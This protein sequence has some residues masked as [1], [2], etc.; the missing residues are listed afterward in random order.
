VLSCSLLALL[1]LPPR[2]RYI[3]CT[4]LASSS[5]SSRSVTILSADNGGCE[6][7]ERGKKSEEEKWKPKEQEISSW[8]D[9]AGLWIRFLRKLSTGLAAQSSAFL[10]CAP[11]VSPATGQSVPFSLTVSPC[12]GT[13][14]KCAI[15]F[16]PPCS[17]CCHPC[18]LRK[19]RVLSVIPFV[20]MLLNRSH[21]REG[22]MIRV[23][24]RGT[25]LS[26]NRNQ[27]IPRMKVAKRE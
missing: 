26:E 25:E 6:K 15:S 9:V 24:I 7:G 3:Q 14:V 2:R 4:R 27:L 22:E 23:E 19:Y 12:R 8:D 21:K 11:C 18:T 17:A 20:M 10:S 13:M 1:L 5:C 16:L